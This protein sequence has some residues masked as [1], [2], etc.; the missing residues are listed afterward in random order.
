[1]LAL[2]VSFLVIALIAALFG[3]RGVASASTGLAKIA[4]FVFLILFFLSLLF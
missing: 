3:F 1:M 2:T 4:F